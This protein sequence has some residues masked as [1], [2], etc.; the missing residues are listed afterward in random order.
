MILLLLPDSTNL[1]KHCVGFVHTSC[2]IFLT[3]STQGLPSNTT[4]GPAVSQ[5]LPA[6]PSG[7][8]SRRSPRTSLLGA[9]HELPIPGAADNTDAS[10][11]VGGESAGGSGEGASLSTL[12]Q[13][14]P[15]SGV[16]LQNRHR[17]PHL[18]IRMVRGAS[19]LFYCCHCRC[20]VTS[21]NPVQ[22]FSAGIKDR[23]ENQ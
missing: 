21:G 23:Q 10:G 17:S 12:M 18:H 2:V 13:L 22:T 19:C 20:Y 1:F 11:R 3:P 8:T 7:V 4:M 5:P 9:A 15:V 16:D 6:N 14:P